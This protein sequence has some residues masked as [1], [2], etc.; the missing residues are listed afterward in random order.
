M[1][2]AQDPL[3]SWPGLLA[4]R[5]FGWRPGKLA[6]S[7]TVENQAFRLGRLA[8]GIHFH[9]QTTPELLRTWAKEDA[10]VL[11]DYDLDRDLDPSRGGPTPISPRSGCRSL[12]VRRDGRSTRRPCGCAASAPGQHRRSDHRPGPDPRRPG[13]RVARQPAPT[14]SRRSRCRPARRRRPGAAA[15]MTDLAATGRGAPCAGPLRL[16]RRAAAEDAARRRRPRRWDSD[17]TPVRPMPGRPSRSPPSVAPPT[18]ML[19]WP[20]SSDSSM[21]PARSAPT[22]SSPPRSAP[23]PRLARRLL[24]LLG[25]STALADHLAAK[26]ARLAGAARRRRALSTPA[27][28]ARIAAASAPTPM[29]RSPGRAAA[30]H[31]DRAPRPRPRCGSPTGAS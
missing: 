26:P 27:R 21:R 20:R 8:G 1:P 7:P 18:P 9:I 22:A 11:D 25:I 31:G 19:R 15:V 12:S 30:G 10:A 13:R 29:T 2:G 5:E 16:P 4:H 17:E 6:G 28:A 24:N 14:P 23:T 3:V